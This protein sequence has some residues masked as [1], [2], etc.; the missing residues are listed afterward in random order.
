GGMNAVP[1]ID[2]IQEFS[3]QTSGYS[4][5][6][7][8]ASGG[9]VNVALKSGTNQVHGFAYDY[10]QNDIFNARPYD[11]TGT[12]PTKQPVRRNLFGAGAGGP[13][14]RNRIFLFGNYEGLRQPANAIEYITVPSALEKQG[15]FTQS[16]YTIYD[17][18]TLRKDPK[19]GALV[20]SAFPGNVLPPT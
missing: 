7:G 11:F 14:I 6:F 18:N 20:R 4:A 3:I 9:I 2:A 12:N 16:G 8:R 13:I 15:N 5:E 10:L 1:P 17:P 19:S